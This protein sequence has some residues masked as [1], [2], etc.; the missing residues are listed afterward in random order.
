MI[1]EF[2]QTFLYFVA[3]KV[4]FKYYNKKYNVI[5]CGISGGSDALLQLHQLHLKITNGRDSCSSFKIL[6]LK[7][8]TLLQMKQ[9][10]V[11]YVYYFLHTYKSM[12]IT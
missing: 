4:A 1:I 5:F 10:N 7:L 12:F 9:L 11:N 3:L 2:N 6:F 8:N